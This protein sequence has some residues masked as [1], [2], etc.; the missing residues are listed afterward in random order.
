MLNVTLTQK[1]KNPSLCL[2]RTESDLTFSQVKTNSAD[3][4]DSHRSC[5]MH[6]HRCTNVLI[7]VALLGIQLPIPKSLIQREN[8]K[9]YHMQLPF[10]LTL[11]TA[12]ASCQAVCLS[13]IVLA[14]SNFN[15]FGFMRVSSLQALKCIT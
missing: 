9:L 10:A 1:I 7:T 4:V 5:S 13:W 8:R 14:T 15:S 12:T 2:L 11:L 6:P 3:D